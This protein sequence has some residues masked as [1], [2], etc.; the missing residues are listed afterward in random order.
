VVRAYAFMAALLIYALFSAPT[1]DNI[2]IAEILVLAGLLT[3]VG[4]SGVMQ[5]TGLSIEENI[6]RWHFPARLLLM[7]GLSVPLVTGLVQG[8]VFS[9]ILRDIIPFLFLLLPLFLSPS[10]TDRTNL[11]KL[12]PYILCLMGLIFVVRVMVSFAINVGAGHAL[13]E[14]MPDPG[15]LVNAPTVLFAALFLTGTGGLWLAESRTIPQALRSLCCFLLALILLAGMAGI[16]QRAHIGA[17]ELTVAL[18]I[19]MLAVKRPLSLWRVGLVL[20][21]VGISLWPFA[22]DILAGLAQKTS[23]VGLNN[24]AEEA[25]AVWESFRDRP[26]AL[27]FGQGWGASI[28]SPAVGPYPVNYTHSLLTTYLLKTGLCGLLLVLAYLGALGAGAWRILWAYPVAGLAVAAPFLIDITLYA[29]FK[30][31]DF[32]LLLVLMALWTRCPPQGR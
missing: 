20:A 18:W 5:V 4:V 15:N 32:G 23:M 25:R 28:T 12:F 10:F 9:L 22:A 29:S 16:G 27:L 8:H 30:T 6:P 13:M 11:A 17:W 26:L 7:F 1:P 31:L 21:V 14:F 2:G 19:G 3:G 24:R